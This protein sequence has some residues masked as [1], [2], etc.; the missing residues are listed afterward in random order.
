MR[1]AI[2]MPVAHRHIWVLMRDDDQLGLYTSLE[3]AIEHA[4]G[5]LHA[6]R[7]H[8]RDPQLFVNGIEVI[9][10]AAATIDP[11]APKPQPATC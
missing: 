6:D 2:T 4:M 11:T 10:R 7:K 5:Q 3:A 8:G 9:V 1:Y